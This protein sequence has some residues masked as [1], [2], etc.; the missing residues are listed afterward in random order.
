MAIDAKGLEKGLEA[1]RQKEAAGRVLFVKAGIFQ[2]ILYR[3]QRPAMPPS[4]VFS[5]A[6]KFSPRFQA[7]LPHRF[8]A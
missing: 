7:Y 4:S 2:A 8:C 1:S 6:V 5:P 3:Q